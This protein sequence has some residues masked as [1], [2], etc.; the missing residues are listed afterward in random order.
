MADLVKDLVCG[1][2]IEL[3]DALQ[4][5]YGGLTYFFCSAECVDRFKE[6]PDSFLL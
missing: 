4:V 5:E 1:M 2:E 6:N 3:R